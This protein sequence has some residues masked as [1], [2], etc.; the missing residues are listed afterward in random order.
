MDKIKIIWQKTRDF[1]KKHWLICAGS[2]GFILLIMMFLPVFRSSWLYYPDSLRGRIAL[3][4]LAAASETG[5]YCHEDC[6]AKSLLYKNIIS[7][8]LAKEKE[9]LLPDLEAAIL[10]FKVLP[11]NRK[12]LIDLWQVSGQEP[13][14]KLKEFYNNPNNPLVLRAALVKAWPQLDSGSGVA[15]MVGSFKAATSEAQ[16]IEI[17]NLLTGKSEA[18]VLKLIWDLILGDYS[19]NLKNKAWFL[20]ANIDNKQI[21][22]QA[23]DLDNLRL[24]LESGTY[25]SRLKDQAILVLNDYY[26]YY[27][28]LSQS[29]L[30]DVVNR[31]KYFDDYQRSF[32]IDILNRY[33]TD[34]IMMPELSLDD[35]NAYFKN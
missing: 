24:V 29:L 15:E 7:S 32:A 4:K 20:L 19:D 22:Y 5:I 34:K 1:I 25:P 30:V 13:S 26:L 31:T 2:F 10:D 11:E 16:K 12:M 18:V 6:S 14:A 28:E 8:A 33:R 21:A 3:K 17:L 9:K 35:W 23:I 27:P